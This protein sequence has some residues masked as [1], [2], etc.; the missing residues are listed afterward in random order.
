MNTELTLLIDDDRAFNL[1]TDIMIKRFTHFTNTKKFEV[2]E[3]ALKFIR[4][5]FAKTPVNCTIFLDINMPSMTGWEV[6]AEIEQL[7][8]ELQDYLTVY[9]VSSSIDT[10]DREKARQ[11]PLVSDFLVK[12]ITKDIITKIFP[13]LSKKVA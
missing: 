3:D 7:P 1:L 9:I 10:D 5:E 12:P 2:P 13:E 6:L 4:E 11:Y 8:K